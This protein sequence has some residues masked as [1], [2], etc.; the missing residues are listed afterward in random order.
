MNKY[1]ASVHLEKGSIRACSIQYI[2]APDVFE[3]T[4]DL[5]RRLKQECDKDTSYEIVSIEDLRYV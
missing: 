4:F 1:R 5:L 2:E 3:A